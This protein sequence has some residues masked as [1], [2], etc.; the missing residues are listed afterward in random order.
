MSKTTKG[1]RVLALGLGRT[2]TLSLAVAL[3]QLGYENVYHDQNMVADKEH[4]AWLERAADSVRPDLNAPGRNPSPFTRA[5]WDEGFGQY[6][7][8]VDW[9]CFFAPAVIKAY[10]DAKVI[11]TVR[12]FDKWFDSWNQ[13]CLVPVFGPGTKVTFFLLW[14]LLGFRSGYTAIKSMRCLYGGTA[15]TLGEYQAQSRRMYDEHKARIISMVPPERLLVYT[16]GKDGWEPLCK[17]L[18]KKVPDTSFPWVNTKPEQTKRVHDAM[19]GVIKK[20][21]LCWAAYAAALA[22]AGTAVVMYRG[23]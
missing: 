12:D 8:I 4:F 2:G 16:V 6:D 11:L 19:G 5:D 21:L 23:K 17:F 9:P 14:W 20:A 15:N 1:P 10:P 22:A 3:G 7:A 13:Q 18:D